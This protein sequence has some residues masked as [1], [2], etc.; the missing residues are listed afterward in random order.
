MFAN[1]DRVEA[2]NENIRTYLA[3]ETV[4]R[5]KKRSKKDEPVPGSWKEVKY[6]DLVDV[7]CQVFMSSS[8]EVLDITFDHANSDV[9]MELDEDEIVEDPE[10]SLIYRIQAQRVFDSASYEVRMDTWDVSP[11]LRDIATY[12]TVPD[13]GSPQFLIPKERASTFQRLSGNGA[14]AWL[15]DVDDLHEFC[16]PHE[17]PTLRDM[18][19][20]VHLSM[21]TAGMHFTDMTDEDVEGYLRS[22]VQG[23]YISTP[24]RRSEVTSSVSCSTWSDEVVR[25]ALPMQH[26]LAGTAFKLLEDVREAYNVGK[27][28]L[29]AVKYVD[30]YLLS[31]AKSLVT[32]GLFIEGFP[33]GPQ[34]VTEH[35]SLD[36]ATF[37]G[38]LQGSNKD[39]AQV[40]RSFYFPEMPD[41]VKGVMARPSFWYR[42]LSEYYYYDAALSG[43]QTQINLGINSIGYG[44][45]YPGF[46]K[47]CHIM[48]TGPPAVGKSYAFKV[49]Q[50]NI[51]AGKVYACNSE[52]KFAATLQN[53]REQCVMIEDENE[54]AKSQSGS[55]GQKQSIL[56]DGVVTRMRANIEKG[57]SESMT[58]PNR[59]YTVTAGNDRHVNHALSSRYIHI[60][61]TGATD[62]TQASA[63]RKQGENYSIGCLA[64]KVNSC[65]LRTLAIRLI[66][67]YIYLLNST[68][69]FSHFPVSCR[70][71]RAELFQ[72]G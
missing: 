47:P 16:L 15:K 61:V 46:G 58:I 20:A 41:E 42:S 44:V 23:A 66:C 60:Q 35:H 19:E 38:V 28:G 33:S 50:A 24:I 31:Q 40:L 29:E 53:V 59:R 48:A 25:T 49:A 4:G 67:S 26:E 32:P 1:I 68:T 14:Y 9:N 36:V 54:D 64:N 5:P 43:Q 13:D 2:F 7:I 57:V 34:R 18:R 17:Q 70:C 30:N 62:D 71:S 37:H 65:M 21:G 11:E 22:T 52:S 6:K 3:K 10:K 8:D 55:T 45:D 39:Q 72:F 63:Y 12:V 69:L 51:C 27:V 56:V